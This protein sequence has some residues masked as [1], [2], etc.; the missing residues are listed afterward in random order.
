MELE[1]K[2][3]LK[4]SSLP[5]NNVGAYLH[6]RNKAYW[7]SSYSFICTDVSLCECRHN[8]NVVNIGEWNKEVKCPFIFDEHEAYEHGRC[9]ERGGVCTCAS[10][11]YEAFHSVVSSL[12]EIYIQIQE[13][14]PAFHEAL[15]AKQERQY[16][17]FIRSIK[18]EGDTEWKPKI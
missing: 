2:C 14:D 12:N 13:Q 10:A 1:N 17:E 6:T 5:L 15:R 9:I 8:P 3:N 11:K 4:V 18:G 16:V 7:Q